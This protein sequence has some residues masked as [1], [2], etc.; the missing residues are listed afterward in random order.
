MVDYLIYTQ[1]AS[2]VAIALLFH[3]KIGKY[4][5]KLVQIRSRKKELLDVM[6]IWGIMFIVLTY[7]MFRAFYFPFL[8]YPSITIITPIRIDLYLILSFIL[9]VLAIRFWSN[10]SETINLGFKKSINWRISALFLVIM[11]VFSLVTFL[12]VGGNSLSLISFIWGIITPALS[13]ELISRGVFTSK[14]ERIYGINKAWLVSGILFGLLHIPNDFFGYFWYLFGQNFIVSLGL[15]L[16][17]I[18]TGWILGIVFIKTR[19]I[20]I[21]FSIHYILDFLPAIIQTI[22]VA[23]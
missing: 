14:L 6:I 10:Q 16:N 8:Y 3:K 7:L 4:P 17:Q 11:I 2:L 12:L 21:P 13:E 20:L 1:V 18:A 23:F 19:S 15:L 9:P 22:I 5:E